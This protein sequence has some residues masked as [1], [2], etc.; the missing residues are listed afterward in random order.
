LLV[1]TIERVLEKTPVVNRYYIKKAAKLKRSYCLLLHRLGL[2]KPHSFVQWLSTYRCNFFCPYCEASAGKA[3]DTELTTEEVKCLIRD[4]SQ[5]RVKRFLISGGEPLVRPDIIEL[6]RYANLKK[7]NLGLVTNGFRVEDLWDEL[8]QFNYFIYF[9]SIDGLQEYNDAVRGRERA[10]EKSMN[11]LELFGKLGVPTR[12][13]NTVVHPGNIDQ[14][15]SLLHIFKNSAANRW[16]LTPTSIVG[17]AAQNSKYN[18]NGEQVKHLV[19]FIKKN[20]NVMNIDL[21]ESH[22]YIG[23]FLGQ[24]LRK[25]FFCGAG[26]TRC[27]IMPDGEVLGCQQVYDN[28]LSEG[29]IRDEPF[30]QIW[31]HKFSRFRDNTFHEYCKGCDFIDGCQ[32]GCWAEMEKQN[33]CLKSLWETGD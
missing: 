12:M 27:S 19:N 10:F 14:L 7:L 4:L 2:L 16:H 26:L 18:L 24:P 6:M 11:G 32:G 33:A 20:K 21:G 29:N 13:I 5:M 23:C 15:E 28:S 3:L 25:A 30:S 31:K 8:K 9:T 1:E 17:R 22:T